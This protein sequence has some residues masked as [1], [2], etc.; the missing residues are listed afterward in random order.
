[1]AKVITFSRVFPTYHPKAGQPTYFV[2]K[3]SN[4]TW[5]AVEIPDF[6]GCGYLDALI[7]LNPSIDEKQLEEFNDA[8]N[9][10][11]KEVKSHTIRLTDR[12]KK[13]DYASLRVWGNDVNPK[14]GRRGAYHSK[15][16]IICPDIE[17]V[18]VWEIES[19]G[20]NHLYLNGK[21][22]NVLDV[23][24]L[25]M[26]DGLNYQDLIDWF[27]YPKPFKGQVICWNENVKY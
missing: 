27:K 3:V 2:E 10:E 7:H 11:I 20:N 4:Y 24:I 8:C 18:N 1:M 16:V 23:E 21:S 6:G 25:A 15:Q 17:I 9:P 22:I 14:S 12:W 26:N 19:T 5:D 13:G